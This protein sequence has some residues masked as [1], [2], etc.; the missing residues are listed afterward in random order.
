MMNP[1]FSYVYFCC[2][3]F[4]L[5]LNLVYLHSPPR[6]LHKVCRLDKHLLAEALE[7]FSAPMALSMPLFGVAAKLLSVL[8]KLPKMWN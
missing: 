1:C 2:L 6:S 7:A 8:E 5:L 3:M 4:S